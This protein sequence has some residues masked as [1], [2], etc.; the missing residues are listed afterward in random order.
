MSVAHGRRG[1]A[2]LVA[3]VAAL[4]VGSA[5]PAAGR[6]GLKEL[7]AAGLGQGEGRV[8]SRVLVHGGRRLSAFPLT[9]WGGVYT[10]KSGARVSVYA[11]STYPV[12][13]AANQ[14]AAD[15]VDSLVHG[16]EIAS[17]KLYFAPPD[18]VG[19]LCG[20]AEADGCY[21]PTTGEIA[22]IG[23]DS[24]WSTVEEVVTHEYGHHVAAN[25]VNTP[26]PAVAWGTKRWA[27]YEGV[28]DKTASGTAFP[29]DEGEHYFQ[30]PGE[31]FAES[32]LHLNEVKLGVTETPWGYDPAFVP[33]AKAL[34]AIEQDVLEPW[35]THSLQHWSGRFSRRG[36]Q[37]TAA[38]QT[39]LDGTVAVQLKGPAGSSLRLSGVP[40]VKRASRTLSAG[41]VCGQRS[42]TVHV[43]AGRA[44]RFTVTAAT[45]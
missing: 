30:N 10:T 8:H 43:T 45:P 24:Q 36:Q 22:S 4:A 11:S 34:A 16:Q 31:S 39:P 13:E 37:G 41:T 42:V 28:C 29:G 5:T 9:A 23:E 3:A 25:R 7:T 2:L 19:R 44:G 18:E 32:Y 17:V 27:T 1:L 33:D 40:N 12:D 14:S 35:T 38:L 6:P 21:S 26:W 15:Y 20:S